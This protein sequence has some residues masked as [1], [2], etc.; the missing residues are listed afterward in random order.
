FMAMTFLV[1]VVYGVVA[2]AFRAWVIESTRIQSALRY[3]F[4][5]A[6]AGLSL[7]LAMSE[8]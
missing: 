6:F 3:G 2:D 1:F 4:A 5:A 8:R 7:R